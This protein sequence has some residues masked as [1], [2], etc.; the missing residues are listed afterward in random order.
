VHQDR[1]EL[2]GAE[3][4]LLTRGCRGPQGGRKTDKR[5]DLAG[6]TGF[7][8]MNR[9]LTVVWW[10]GRVWHDGVGYQDA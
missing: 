4:S 2:S 9:T 7:H 6:Q 10:V 5:T 1:R 3:A 8:V